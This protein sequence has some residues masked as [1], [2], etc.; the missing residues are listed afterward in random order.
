MAV[1][2]EELKQKAKELWLEGK[3][4]R[5]ISEITGIKESS[6]KSLANRIWKKEKLQPKRK[7]VATKVS[8]SKVANAPLVDELTDEE[9]ETLTNSDLTEKQRLFCLYY[10]RSF[11]ATSAYKKAYECS[12]ATA[13]TNGPGLLRKARIKEEITKLKKERCQRELLT[14]E[15]IFQKYMD[16]AFAD[17]T[18]FLEFGQEEVEVMSAFGPVTITDESTGDKTVLKKRVNVVKFKDSAEVDGTLIGEVKQGKDGA[19]IKLPDRMKALQWLA[20]HMDFAT[21]EQ[22]A[23]LE[24]LQA[25][26]KKLEMDDNERDDTVLEKMDAIAGIAMQMKEPEEDEYA[27]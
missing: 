24:L 23:R 10:S 7:K 22:K 2:D 17:I 25:Q 9:I 20:D 8:V 4:Y 3:K 26:K 14:Q 6:I 18:D 13:M 15:D 16:I 21:A 27:E 19:S 12:Y 1:I 5:E 11:N